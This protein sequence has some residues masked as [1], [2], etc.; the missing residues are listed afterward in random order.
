MGVSFAAAQTVVVNLST[1]S[2]EMRRSFQPSLIVGQYKGWSSSKA[3]NRKQAIISAWRWKSTQ[4]RLFES[5]PL[6][7]GTLYYMQKMLENIQSN[8]GLV[9]FFFLTGSV[10]L[11][12]YCF[13]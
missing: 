10:E 9:C 12:V 7:P 3:L 11:Y 2:R 13:P 1:I 4:E 5:L 8:A 6:Q